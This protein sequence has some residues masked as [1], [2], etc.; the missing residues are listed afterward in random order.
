MEGQSCYSCFDLDFPFRPTDQKKASIAAEV[1]NERGTGTGTG[2]GTETETGTGTGEE[3]GRGGTIPDRVPD[4]GLAP[5]TVTGTETEIGTEIVVKERTSLPA[6]LIV[7]PA[8]G[9]T[10]IKTLIAGKT[11]TWTGLLPRSLLLAT[12]ITAK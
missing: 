7:H 5:G 2:T 10:W 3:T 6:G 4:P 9:K 8:P 11:N 1:E 12:F